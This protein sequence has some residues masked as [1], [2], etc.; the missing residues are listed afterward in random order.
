MGVQEC[1]TRVGTSEDRRGLW[2]KLEEYKK[3]WNRK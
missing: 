1:T 3:K 2:W